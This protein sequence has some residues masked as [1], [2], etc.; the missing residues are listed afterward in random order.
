MVETLRAVGNSIQGDTHNNLFYAGKASTGSLNPSRNR[1]ANSTSYKSLSIQKK[2]LLKQESREKLVPRSFLLELFFCHRTPDV[3]EKDISPTFFSLVNYLEANGTETVGIFRREGIKQVYRDIVW[4]IMS[5]DKAGYNTASVYDFTPYPILELASALK[6]YIREVLDGLFDYRLMRKAL[7]AI[8]Q[9]DKQQAS[10]C[11]RYLMFSLS[12]SQ[13]EFFIILKSM[14]W[15]IV[16]KKEINKMG[17]E[18]ICNIFSLTICPLETFKSVHFIPV[19]VEFFRC[20][21]EID[22]EDIRDVL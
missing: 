17:W 19:A 3:L 15:S 18:S 12:R 22:P 21:M 8:V 5:F 1:D 7:D 4:S 14:L 16:E 20:I 11:C 13:R 2:Q 9:N 6:F 10:S